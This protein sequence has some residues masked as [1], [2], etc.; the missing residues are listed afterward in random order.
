MP[1]LTKEQ[2]KLQKK[3]IENMAL[4]ELKQWLSACIYNEENVSH[5]KARRGWRQERQNTEA[6][7]EKLST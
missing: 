6:L 2:V 4:E 3:G 5:N 7:I 1:L